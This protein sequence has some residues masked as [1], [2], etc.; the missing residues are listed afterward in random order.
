MHLNVLSTTFRKQIVTFS[1]EHV[2]VS[3]HVTLVFLLASRDVLISLRNS[4]QFNGFYP[5]TEFTIVTL[6][7]LPVHYCKLHKLTGN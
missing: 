6:I 3:N 4:P 7:V 2:R 5:I 1:D